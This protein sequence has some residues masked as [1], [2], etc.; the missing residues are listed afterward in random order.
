MSDAIIG[1]RDHVRRAHRHGIEQAARDSRRPIAEEHDRA[2]VHAGGPEQLIAVLLGAGHRALVRLDAAAGPERLQAHP[3]VDAAGAARSPA[4]CPIPSHLVD[5]DRRLALLDQD[6]RS[7]PLGEGACRGPVTTVRLA[8]WFGS[9]LLQAYRVVWVTLPE[10]R[11]LRRPD[12]VV[13][14]ADHGGHIGTEGGRIAERAK[15]SGAGHARMVAAGRPT[16][17]GRP[18]PAVR[19]RLRV[20]PAGPTD[21][22]H[23][24][25]ARRCC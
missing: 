20:C 16:G 10:G 23:C 12:D 9:G 4:A 14:R 13:R 19:G 11:S 21:V 18:P 2:E 15:G 24:C 5:V 1:G 7:P 6:P 22:S 3:Q 25:S 8:T 17:S